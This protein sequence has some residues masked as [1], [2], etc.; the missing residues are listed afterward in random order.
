M[1]WMQTDE[2]PQAADLVFATREVR[3]DWTRLNLEL[4]CPT[5]ERREGGRDDVLVVSVLL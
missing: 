4:L 1:A 5:D 2:A 3:K